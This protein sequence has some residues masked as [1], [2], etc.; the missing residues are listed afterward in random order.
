MS[1]FIYIICKTSCEGEEIIARNIQQQ[2]TAM[3]TRSDQRNQL[4]EVIFYIQQHIYDREK[5]KVDA[6]ADH[7]SRSK[8][9]II[10]FFEARTGITLRDYTRQYK[11]NL[12]KSRLQF[13]DMTIADS[14]RTGVYGRKSPEQDVQGHLSYTA[15]D[16]KKNMIENRIS[17]RKTPNRKTR[18]LSWQFF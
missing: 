12:V 8:N 9:Y 16:F 18:D 15:N 2:L 17:Q 6:L 7:I 3:V 1:S 14:R 10:E 11:L 4:Q 5:L 13:S